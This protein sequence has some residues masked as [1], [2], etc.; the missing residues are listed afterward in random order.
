MCAATT[1]AKSRPEYA[2]DVVQEPVQARMVSRL[3][4]REGREDIWGRVWGGSWRGATVA[5][6]VGAL[7]A[8]SN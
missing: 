2:L 8:N 7:D 3:G 5:Y 6:A 4:G 1:A